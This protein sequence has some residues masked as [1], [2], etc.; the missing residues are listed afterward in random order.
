MASSSSPW[1]R[2]SLTDVGPRCPRGGSGPYFS[3]F[4]GLAMSAIIAA[5]PPSKSSGVIST[6]C[7][8]PGGSA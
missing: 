8:M 6:P 1:D 5:G 2:D 7:L 4:S 3:R